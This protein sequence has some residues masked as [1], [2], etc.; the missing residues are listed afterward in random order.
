[1]KKL[2]WLVVIIAVLV[3]ALPGL[4]GIMAEREVYRQMEL[5]EDSP[6]VGLRISKF[7][8]GWFSSD[9]IYEY[10]LPEAYREA[11]QTEIEPLELTSHVTHGPLGLDG[12]LFFG[13][14]RADTTNGN[15]NPRVKQ[16]LSDVGM[17]SL[18]NVRTTTGFFGTTRFEGYV[19]KA[20]ADAGNMPSDSELISFEFSGMALNGSY[21][22]RT[23]KLAMEGGASSLNMVSDEV[24]FAFANLTLATDMTSEADGVPMG[25]ADMNV[26]SLSLFLAN[27]NPPQLMNLTDLGFSAATKAGNATDMADIEARYFVG[28]AVLAEN[29]ITDAE[30]LF[31]ARNL[32]IPALRRYS[33]WSKGVVS[34]DQEDKAAVEQRLEELG[35]IMHEIASS[36]PE[37]AIEPL[38]FTT[39]GESF[40]SELKLQIDGERL[41]PS[42]SF[43]G[44]SA[45]EWMKLV[46][47][48]AQVSISEPLATTLA[49]GNARSKL[50]E[51]L[52]DQQQITSEQLDG[53]AAVQAPMVLEALI[54]QGI[55]KRQD[56]NLESLI[57]YKDGE[58]VLNGQAIPVAALMGL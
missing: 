32:L 9:V 37:F 30:L 51:T 31:H 54:Q 50:Q 18:F 4:A 53:M 35:S 57:V 45:A 2:I 25:E 58:L 44:T 3:L 38:K 43:A 40:D 22:S 24:S 16:F 19:P 20:T 49:I 52:G 55:V 10:G 11:M 17:A 27:A 29:T 42:A 7:D 13:M 34:I 12:G 39:D 8:R 41:P 48:E 6:V 56:G 15:N 46:T 36:S 21:N 14:F 26:Q 5:I 1:M 47:G 33:E 28:R 23:R